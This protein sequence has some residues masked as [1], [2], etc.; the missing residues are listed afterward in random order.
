MSTE[1]TGRTI[2]ITPTWSDILP[3]LLAIIANAT[4]YEARKAAEDE[5]RRMARLADKFVEVCRS[6]AAGNET[7]R[8]I[9]GK[10]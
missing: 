3:A 1:Y 5:L 4:T 2:D 9:A 10:V 7:V 6:D 8:L